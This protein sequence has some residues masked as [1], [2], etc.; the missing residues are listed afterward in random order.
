MNFDGKV[1]LITG[2]SSGIGAACVKEFAARKAAVAII[3]RQ[4]LAQGSLAAAIGLSI[5]GLTSVVPRRFSRSFA[6]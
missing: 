6:R 4:P 5:S 3:D 1:V 2:G